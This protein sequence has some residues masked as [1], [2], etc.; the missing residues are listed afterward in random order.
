MTLRQRLYCMKSTNLD[1]SPMT[2]LTHS[3]KT[4][5]H[6]ESKN[7]IDSVLA[8]NPKLEGDL[9]DRIAKWCVVYAD[10][11]DVSDVEI[12]MKRFE[13]TFNVN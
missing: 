6:E 5:L 4:S 1:V 11:N 2:K 12:A 7:Y 13:E 10:S 9:L 8:V 3:T